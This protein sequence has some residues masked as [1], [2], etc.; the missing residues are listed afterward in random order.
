MN[1][2]D[3]KPGD[4]FEIIRAK[5]SISFSDASGTGSQVLLA[6]DVGS[7]RTLD[8]KPVVGPADSLREGDVRAFLGRVF[9][10]VEMPRVGVRFCPSVWCRVEENKR[11]LLE[12]ALKEVN[13]RWDY[14]VLPSPIY[15]HLKKGFGDFGTN[16]LV[17]DEKNP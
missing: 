15:E 3:A 9:R 7:W 17:F 12:F 5:T 14:C 13:L 8:F 11:D 1:A 10:G 6:V 2:L 16:Q 4:W